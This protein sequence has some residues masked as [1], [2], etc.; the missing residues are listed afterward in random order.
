MYNS[1]KVC[2]LTF[3]RV[4]LLRS[5][6]TRP[7]V[8]EFQYEPDKASKGKAIPLQAWADPQVSRNLRLPELIDNWCMKVV[9]LSALHIGSL[10]SSGNVPATHFC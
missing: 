9:K 1:C 6:D 10:K 2:N 3:C 4:L 5:H 8:S 7:I